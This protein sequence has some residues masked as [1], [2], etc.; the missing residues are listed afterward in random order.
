MDTFTLGAEKTQYFHWPIVDRTEPMW[1]LGIEFRGLAR[2]HDDVVFA[3]DQSQSAVENVKPFVTLVD[4]RIRVGASGI[5]DELVGLHPTR[6]PSEGVDRHMLAPNRR[7]AH[8]RIL[9]GRCAHKFVQ[10]NLVCPGD[11][12]E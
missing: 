7:R 4:A 6:A 1:H 8:P 11:R 3:E 5:D 9:D 10:G 2:L 12:E